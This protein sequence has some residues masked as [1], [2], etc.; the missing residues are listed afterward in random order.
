MRNGM[1]NGMLKEVQPRAWAKTM[2]APS[3]S[4]TAPP[5]AMDSPAAPAAARD[6]GM[7]S[8]AFVSKVDAM[9]Y[10]MM[11]MCEKVQAVNM[12]MGQAAGVQPSQLKLST[13]TMFCRVRA[14][15]S[16]DLSK[17]IEFFLEEGIERVREMMGMELHIVFPMRKSQRTSRGKSINNFFNQLTFWYKDGTKKSV[18]L[19]INGNIHATGCRSVREFVGLVQRVCGF[20][21]T[22]FPDQASPC[23]AEDL[24]IQMINTN[25]GVGVGLDLSKLK[26]ILLDGGMCA[27]YDR[28]VYPGLNLK[29]P[30]A[31]GREASVLVFI[32]G[33]IIITGVKSFLE[34]YEAYHFIV[35]CIS[36]RLGDVSKVRL[37]VEPSDKKRPTHV[38]MRDGY[39]EHILDSILVW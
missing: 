3:E 4:R 37:A 39:E 1:R 32:S 11:K 25:F 30:T 6:R 33:N 27:T 5:P 22:M 13:M 17:V 23:I 8:D 28:E 16:F 9:S 20:V 35:G 31:A 21:N 12:T 38:S 14:P 2:S 36:G 19:F 15:P 18:K 26:R 7:L 34:V 10:Q 29:V 24:D